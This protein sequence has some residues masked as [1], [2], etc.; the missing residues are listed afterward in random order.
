M[1]HSGE[2]DGDNG[3]CYVCVGAEVYGKSLPSFLFYCKP[4]SALKW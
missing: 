4:K 3:G 2:C 1:Y